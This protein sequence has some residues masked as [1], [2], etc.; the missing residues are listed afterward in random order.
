MTDLLVKQQGIRKRWTTTTSFND[1][2]QPLGLVVRRLVQ[3][4]F[5]IPT[6]VLMVEAQGHNV[7]GFRK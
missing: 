5:P 7:E 6:A 3:R 2:W 4:G 1:N